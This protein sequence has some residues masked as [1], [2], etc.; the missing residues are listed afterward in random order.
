MGS[1]RLPGKVLKSM[2]GK[3][4]IEWIIKRLQTCKKAGLLIVA[5]SEDP[6]E[7]PLVDL[8]TRLGVP[9]FRGSESD[10]LERYYRCAREYGLDDI[11][12]ATADNP[13]VDPGACDCLVSYYRNHQL[14]YATIATGTNTGFPIGVG[15]EVFSFQALKKCYLEG[16]AP[17]HR[18]HVNEYIL[19][20]PRLFK[21]AF[22]AAPAELCAPEI[23][24]TVDTRAQF[25]GIARIYSV[26]HEAH[27]SQP[28]P[29]SW[30]I[31][32]IKHNQLQ[33]DGIWSS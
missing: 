23:S 1:T 16:H 19:E 17:H 12:R 29:A 27:P 10:V 33:S 13:L 26:Y 6:R 24:L 8:L 9:T 18:E 31:A 7:A 20:N 11:I 4:M 3:P 30:A 22:M 25:E 32:H 28:V 2:A 5:T 14:D 21:Q 15:L